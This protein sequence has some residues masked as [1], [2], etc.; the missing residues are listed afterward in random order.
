MKNAII[1]VRV[2]KEEQARKDLKSSL[3]MQK[4]KCL[5]YCKQNNIKP[6]K[7]LQDVQS[8]GNDN[9][10]G[11][12]ELQRELETG[13]YDVVVVYEISRISRIASTGL[14]FANM[15]S[16]ISV[17]FASIMQPKA[18]KFLLG[19]LFS[20][21]EEERT[22]G[23]ERTK[24]NKLARAK[25]GFYQGKA[26]FGYRNSRDTLIIIEEEAEIVR[27]MYHEYIYS[28]SYSKL[29]K[30][31]DF[32]VGTVKSILTNKAYTG[33]FKYGEK[34]RDNLFQKYK[35]NKDVKYYK[36][37][38]PAIIEE[39]T[40][41]KV[42]E[43]IGK[44]VKINAQNPVILFSGLVECECGSKMYQE[45]KSKMYKGEKRISYYYKCNSCKKSFNSKKEKIIIEAIKKYKVEDKTPEN[46]KKNNLKILNKLK[47][48]LE[49]L[50]AKKERI[51]ELHIN[52]LMELEVVKEK[53]KALDRE[54][55]ELES[56]IKLYGTETTATPQEVLDTKEKLIYILENY[57]IENVGDIR[58]VL[59]LLIKKIKMNNIKK[60]DFSIEL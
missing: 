31:Y 38:Y 58:K 52:G 18:N 49:Q 10:I 36:G 2:S 50:P 6:L 1:Y 60:F 59:R 53:C 32:S 47:R 34:V 28:F 41:N 45:R 20:V 26:P 12:L 3:E 22:Q 14:E 15:L 27:E 42:Q 56:K 48:E 25:K 13:L 17:E 7:I 54:K 44:R 23:S 5:D 19:I 30:L 57:N 8:G 4:S 37:N 39:E 55:K 35:K 11:F 9:R 24:T 29:G 21:A 43:A 40:Y 33:W 46:S 16:R 51:T